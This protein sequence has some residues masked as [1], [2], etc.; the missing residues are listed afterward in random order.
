[1][2]KPSPHP[3]NPHRQTDRQT[4]VYANAQANAHANA[5]AH[6]HAHAPYFRKA[7]RKHHQVTSQHDLLSRN[8]WHIRIH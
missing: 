5:H 1:M 7:D 2:L 8:L 6:A 4:D 3:N